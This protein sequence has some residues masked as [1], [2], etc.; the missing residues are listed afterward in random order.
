MSLIRI[1]ENTRINKWKKF[2]R[3][4]IIMLLDQ[5]YIN[6]NKLGNYILLG[7]YSLARKTLLKETIYIPYF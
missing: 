6:H 2:K 7:F 1:S 4:L 5:L 3:P